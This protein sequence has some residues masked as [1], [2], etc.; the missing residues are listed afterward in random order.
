[1]LFCV[2]ASL[3]KKGTFPKAKHS[4]ILLA[5]E[6]ALL[7][8]VPFDV[9]QG[10]LRVCSGFHLM[11]VI[12]A[13][14]PDLWMHYTDRKGQFLERDFPFLVGRGESPFWQVHV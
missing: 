12:S 8:L 3:I 6:R 2:D 9:W 10:V 7:W 11:N 13:D 4:Q 1:M 14:M 5:E